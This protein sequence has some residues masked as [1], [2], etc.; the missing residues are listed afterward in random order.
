M[1][2]GCGGIISFFVVKHVPLT[3]IP[4]TYVPELQKCSEILDIFG[5]TQTMRKKKTTDTPGGT[6]Y[7]YLTC[8][9]P[10]TT[11]SSATGK[12]NGACM[13]LLSKDISRIT[14]HRSLCGVPCK[15][16]SEG[17]RNIKCKYLKAM[18]NFPKNVAF[19]VL[20]FN[21]SWLLGATCTD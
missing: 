9:G 11:C 18:T 8:Y 3:R 21:T 10:L 19:C 15:R 14:D 13:I 20:P 2:C 7:W 6:V 12:P 17:L 16:N 1:Y 5:T 4:N